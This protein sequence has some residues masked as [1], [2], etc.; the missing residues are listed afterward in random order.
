MA[1]AIDVARSS[2]VGSRLA[3]ID[4]TLFARLLTQADQAV[5][6]VLEKI[7]AGLRSRKANANAELKAALSVTREVGNADL[8]AHLPVALVAAVL[9]PN[10]VTADDFDDLRQRFDRWTDAAQETAVRELARLA[11]DRLSDRDIERL[12]AKQSQDRDEAWA[13]LLAA[14]IASTQARLVRGED[15]VDAGGEWNPNTTVQPGLIRTALALAG[16][17][18]IAATD[19][20]GV[21]HANGGPAGGVATGDTMRGAFAETGH[22][23]TGY[24]WEYGSAPRATPF[25][26]H[27]AL[28]GAP[29]TEWGEFAP[30]DHAGCLCGASVLID[31][32]GSDASVPS[33]S[34]S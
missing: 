27:L 4:S 7:G 30:S 32:G 19:K 28:D 3:A 23:F 15:Q 5:T 25:E 14:L 8:A 12:R 22:P 24:I 21:T 13:A 34:L 9:G 2:T 29:D 17:S 11:G 26:E 6:R 31:E 1:A 33:D 16:G 18:I 10:P 20:G